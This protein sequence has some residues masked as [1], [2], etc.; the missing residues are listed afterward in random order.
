MPSARRSELVS[1]G[2][3]MGYLQLL[4]V[5]LALVVMTSSL[6]A[7]HVVGATASQLAPATVA[8][9]LIVGAAELLRRGGKRSL[10]VFSWVLLVDGLYL[11]WVAYLS[12]GPVSPLRFLVYIHIVAVSLVASYRTG[13]KVTLWH[14]L[15]LLATYYGEA[16]GI[17]PVDSVAADEFRRLAAFSVIAMWLFAIITATF[18]SLNERELRRR[19]T[20]LEG[21]AGLAAD[22]ESVSAPDEV[23]RTLGRHLTDVFGFQRAV[24]VRQPAW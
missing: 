13:L 19:R 22:L 14:S 5:G 1:L 11:A 9:G 15:L 10:L 18:S 23:A 21:L 20:D 2:Q 3:R 7:P 6:V 4:R 12:G 16:T 24:V 17:I 8:Y